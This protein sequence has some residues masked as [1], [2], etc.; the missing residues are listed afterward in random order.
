MDYGLDVW[1]CYV[2][3]VFDIP[4]F[5]TIKT[6]SHLTGNKE[7]REWILPLIYTQCPKYKMRGGLTS[8]PFTCSWPG[9]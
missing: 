9:A 8:S 6:S 2:Q 4:P 3:N 5:H 7:G 1:M